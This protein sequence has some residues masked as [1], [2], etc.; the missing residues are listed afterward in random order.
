MARTI[1]IRFPKH[2]A[3]EYN[4]IHRLRNY[5]EDVYRHLQDSDRGSGE[6]DLAEVDAATSQFS[7][8]GVSPRRL[9]R[10]LKWVYKE[11]ARQNLQID[12]EVS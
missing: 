10:V 1:V 8:R 4:L 5:G 6:I 2:Q 9:Q 3:E 7:I 11:A 12:T